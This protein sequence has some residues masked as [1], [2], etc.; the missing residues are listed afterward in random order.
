MLKVPLRLQVGVSV[1]TPGILA[2]AKIGAG[3]P[4]YPG[5]F[6]L[7]LLKDSVCIMQYPDL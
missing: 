4:G 5:V 6:E 1:S 2:Y 3:M 7:W